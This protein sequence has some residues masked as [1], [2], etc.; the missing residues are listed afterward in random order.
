MVLTAF[1]G[2]I[3]ELW[4]V[5]SSLTPGSSNVSVTGKRRSPATTC[6]SACSAI[7]VIRQAP[8]TAAAVNL[9]FIGWCS[10]DV[11][12]KRRA[13]SATSDGKLKSKVEARVVRRRVRS[14]VAAHV[15][16]AAPLHARKELP[17]AAMA[18]PALASGQR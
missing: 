5:T 6:A 16:A 18:T 1:P 12:R 10:F 11:R 15:P 4:Q 9:F 13:V 2:R 3:D 17:R 14:P 7:A 8:A